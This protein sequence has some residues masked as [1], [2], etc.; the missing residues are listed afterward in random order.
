MKIKTKETAEIGI[1]GGTGV[2]EPSML[3]DKKEIKVYSPYGDPSGPITVGSFEGRN[4][5]FLPRH[6]QGHRIPPHALPFRANIWAMKELGVNR[7]L[8]P[9]AVGSLKK[10][11]EPGHFV[12]P[13]QFIDRTGHS[14][15]RTFYPGG[16]V[17]HI[18]MADPFCPQLSSHVVEKANTL[19]LTVH[20]E[21]TY[22]CI[23]GPR[24]STRAESKMFRQWGGDIIGM[25]L[26]PEVTLAR[27]AG[28]CYTTVGMVTDYDVWAEKPVTAE[29]VA[30]TMKQNIK[31]VRELL[32][33]VIPTIPKEKTCKCE[34]HI[35]NAYQ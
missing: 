29:E 17:A 23:Q 4:V 11:I 26:V 9:S 21:G 35:K 33:N 18:S 27:E 24:F 30:E 32:S 22:V 31:K 2:Y 14:R 7:I 6:G 8:A 15:P 20:E 16:V 3:E 10:D 5:A 1:I 13:D 25:T 19:D 28:I 34:E 12:I